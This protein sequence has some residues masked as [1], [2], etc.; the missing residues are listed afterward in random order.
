MIKIT[1]REALK[2]GALTGGSLL[3]PIGLLSR[4][5]AA[6]AGSPQPTRFSVKLPIPPVLTAIFR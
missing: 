6:T 1:R 4:G 2:L 3:I 5:Q